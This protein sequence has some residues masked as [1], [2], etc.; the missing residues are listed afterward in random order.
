MNCIKKS[1]YPPLDDLP[2][3]TS[4]SYNSTINQPSEININV[5]IFKLLNEYDDIEKNQKFNKCQLTQFL[6]FNREKI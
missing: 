6:Y 5:P 4:I 2:L 3:K 1:I